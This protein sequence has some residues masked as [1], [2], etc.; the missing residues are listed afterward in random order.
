MLEECLG[1]DDGL[2]IGDRLFTYLWLSLHTPN[3]HAGRVAR[4]IEEAE[5][6]GKP[7]MVENVSMKAETTPVAEAE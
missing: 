1:G 2:R 5:R 7:E 6:R 3:A 4:L